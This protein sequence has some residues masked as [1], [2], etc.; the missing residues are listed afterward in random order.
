MP[1]RWQKLQT[2]IIHL[3]EGYSSSN[4]LVTSEY[5]FTLDSSDNVTLSN[6][7]IQNSQTAVMLVR[8]SNVTKIENTNIQNCSEAIK[9]ESS[10]VSA[11]QNSTLSKNGNSQLLTGAAIR[12]L[13]S[14]V[15]IQNSS[16]S[17]NTAISGASVYFTC[18]SMSLCSLSI[19]DSQ[20]RN[21]AATEKGGAI[22]YDYARPSFGSAIIFENNSALYGKDIGSYG[23]K[24]TFANDSTSQLRIDDVGS[25]ITYPK[26]LRFSVRDYDDQVMN[27][28]N[29]DQIRMT[30]TDSTTTEIGGYNSGILNNLI[31]SSSE[32]WNCRV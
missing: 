26:T 30:A 12:I 16:F 18:S 2:D 19:D 9:I 29:E 7:E 25:G 8:S 17:N 31:Y 11:I 4:S 5:L 22:Y 28:D 24:I 1:K 21:N 27:L 20:F 14:S 32:E 6:F 3:L 15:N 13:D 10:T 23:V